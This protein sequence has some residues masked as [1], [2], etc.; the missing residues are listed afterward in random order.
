MVCSALWNAARSDLLADTDAPSSSSSWDPLWGDRCQEL[1]WIGINMDQASQR[2]MLDACLLTDEE[3]ALGPE[4][5]SQFE[6]PLPDWLTD[7][8]DDGQLYDDDGDFDEHEDD[9][10]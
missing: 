5:W 9:S 2:A 8:A 4:G 3:M 10:Q 7:E 1:V 6:D